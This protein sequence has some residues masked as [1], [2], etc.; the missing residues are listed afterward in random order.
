MKSVVLAVVWT[1]LAACGGRYEGPGSGG[2][3]T[4]AATESSTGSGGSKGSDSSGTTITLPKHDL[5]TCTPGFERASNPNRSCNWLTEAGVCFDTKDAAC[6]CICPR[7]ADSVCF[8]GFDDGP[9][10]A[11]LVHCT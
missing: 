7:N 1:A 10:S 4:G 11:T 8:S 2:S 6:A 3:G 9:G 5:G